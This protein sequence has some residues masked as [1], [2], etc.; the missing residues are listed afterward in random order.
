MNFGAKNNKLQQKAKA[1]KALNDLVS[2]VNNLVL[3]PI[4]DTEDLHKDE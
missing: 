3:D 2:A 4:D 1:S